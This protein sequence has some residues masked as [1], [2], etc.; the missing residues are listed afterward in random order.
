LFRYASDLQALRRPTR[1]VVSGAPSLI[2]RNFVFLVPKCSIIAVKPS[3]TGPLVG[4][5]SPAMKG[6]SDVPPPVGSGETPPLYKLP[7]LKFQALC[8][9]LLDSG[10]DAQISACREYGTPGQQ[11]HGVDL[12]ADRRDGGTDVAQCKCAYDFP[13]RAIRKASALAVEGRSALHFARWQ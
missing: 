4:S 10:A 9:D 8:R 11:Q 1:Q 2:G 7:G 3:V 13:P 6:F 12:I 5:Q